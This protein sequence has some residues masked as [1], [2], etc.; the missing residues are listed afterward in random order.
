MKTLDN[1]MTEKV[2]YDVYIN[3][4]SEIEYGS[5]KTAWKNLSDV[6]RKLVNEI[7]AENPTPTD[8][9]YLPDTSGFEETMNQFV[10]LIYTE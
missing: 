3:N 9:D 1:M 4:L 10:K 2:T 8:Y 6:L 7:K 5:V